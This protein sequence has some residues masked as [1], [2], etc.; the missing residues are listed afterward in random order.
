MDGLHTVAIVGLG[1]RG[2]DTYAPIVAGMNGRAKIV[3]IADIDEKK[4]QEVREL[5]SVAEEN[6][7]DSAE[8]L[9]A[10]GKLADV[11]FG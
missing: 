1:S 11:M 6:C 10:A 2:K 7:F 8:A 5:Y 3:A 9:L 4:V